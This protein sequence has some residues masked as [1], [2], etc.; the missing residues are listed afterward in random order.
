MDAQ[1]NNGAEEAPALVTRVWSQRAD[2]SWTVNVRVIS[3]SAD[4][5]EWRTSVALYD[6]EADARAAGGTHTAWC[7]ADV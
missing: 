5:P 2:G 4:V 7:P 1:K 3:D 6:T